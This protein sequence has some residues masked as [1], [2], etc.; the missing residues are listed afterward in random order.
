MEQTD[1]ET[2]I[3]QIE[4]SDCGKPFSI[5]LG[6]KFFY[7]TKGLFYPPKRCPQCRKIRRQTIDRSGRE[8]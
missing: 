8:A 1:Y 5:R 4:C 7:Q 6:E 3:D 2:I